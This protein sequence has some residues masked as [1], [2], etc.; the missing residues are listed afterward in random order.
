MRILLAEDEA[1]QALQI[2]DALR[3]DN[4]LVSIARDGEEA[5]AYL[6][7]DTFDMLIT[8]LDLPVKT[9]YDVIK[10]VRE[11][12]NNAEM[13]IIVE[14]VLERE[15]VTFDEIAEIERLITKP[16]DIDKFVQSLQ[17]VKRLIEQNKK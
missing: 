15:Q 1:I 6:K 8:D 14:T 4:N 17:Y 12:L 13:P 3:N 11:D 5:I 9:G 10:Y 16:F 7:S 2:A